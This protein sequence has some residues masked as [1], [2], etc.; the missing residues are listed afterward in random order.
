MLKIEHLKKNYDTFSLDCS[1]ELRP[2]YVTGLIGQNGAGKSTTF[3]AVLGLIAID[4]GTITILG[5]DIR[6]FTAKDREKLGVVLSDSGFSGYLR[7]KDLIPILENLYEKFDKTFFVE[8]AERFRLPPDKQIKDFSTGMKAKLKLL[9]A[10]SHDAKLLILDEPTA[11]LDVIARDELLE[12]LREFMEQDEERSVLI[13]SHISGDLESLC[14]D[15]Y[16]IQDGKIVL[17]ED[18]DVLLSEYALL[19]VDEE[20]Y[21]KLDKQ[22]I[23]RVKKETYGYSCLTNQKQFYIENFPKIAIEKGTVDEVISLMVRGN[24]E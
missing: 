20:Q 22:Y 14:D 5:K 1:L 13:S 15:L 8:Q 19:K 4:G 2:G 17:H 9:A 23:L 24:E 18:T 3:K 21:E 10:I 16:M 12:L 7:I 11:G 6:E